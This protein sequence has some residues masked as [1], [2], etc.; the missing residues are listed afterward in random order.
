[1]TADKWKVMSTSDKKTLKTV[2]DE[3]DSALKGE[4]GIRLDPEYQRDYK[5]TQKDESMLIESILMGIPLPIIYL[6][7]DTRS[8]PHVANIIDGQH[9]LR[10]L[11]RYLKNEFC[12]K[13]VE[14][15]NQ[16]L[17]QSSLTFKNIHVQDNAELEME[18]FKRY[19]IGTHP[20]SQQEIRHA[21]YRSEFNIWLNR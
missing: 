8:V 14:F 6:S 9:R 1:M 15:Q 7:S 10:A 12:L 18:I 20:L 19:N 21:V 11:Y 13:G 4:S 3:I 5:F 16:L 17:F 2:C